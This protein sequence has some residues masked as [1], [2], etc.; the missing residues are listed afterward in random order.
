M[1]SIS[2]DERLEI[3]RKWGGSAQVAEVE[4]VGLGGSKVLFSQE[5]KDWIDQNSVIKV[6]VDAKR[7]PIEFLDRDGVYKGIAIDLLND[8]G[9]ATGL[10]FQFVGEANWEETLEAVSNGELD[11]VSSISWGGPGRDEKYRFTESYMNLVNVVFANEKASYL[12]SLD[13]LEGKTIGMTKGYAVLDRMKM[14]YPNYDYIEVKDMDE[15]LK[16]VNTGQIDVYIDVFQ[17]T[18]GRM[19]SEGIAGGV[20]VIGYTPYTY[21]ISMGTSI[22]NEMLYKILDK[23]LA[24]ISDEQR[25]DILRKWQRITVEESYNLESIIK[26]ILPIILVLGIFI[27]WTL[28]L[29]KEISKRKKLENELVEARNQAEDANDAKS[30]FFGQHVS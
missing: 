28:R 9:G 23:G 27:S 10:E 14:D 16:Q 13:E 6:G 12:N 19:Q 1:A 21:D 24:S 20:K 26:F 15:G 18:A 30:R 2:D 5:E 22:E 11:M 3:F 29:L 4:S 7:S 8:I 25:S 17:T